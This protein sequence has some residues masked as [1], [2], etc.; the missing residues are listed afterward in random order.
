MNNF[1]KPGINDADLLKVI[2]DL[3]RTPDMITLHTYLGIRFYEKNR[4]LLFRTIND[5]LSKRSCWEVMFTDS[6]TK[7]LTNRVTAEKLIGRLPHHS[8][9]KINQSCILNRAFLQGIC[10]K[11][12]N[13]ELFSPYDKI[14]LTTSRIEF[15][16]IK[17]L[18]LK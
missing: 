6:T 5:P 13:C 16:R 4:I 14:I 18:L 8:F 2:I 12:R 1:E 10:Y 7:K 9:I 11:T 17:A 15:I 3:N